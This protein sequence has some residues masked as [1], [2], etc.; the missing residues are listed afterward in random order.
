[1]AADLKDLHAQP[2]TVPISAQLYSRLSKTIVLLYAV[3]LLVT[4]VGVTYALYQ[5]WVVRIEAA[6]TDLSRSASM[7]NF[8]VE[9]ALISAA[10]TLDEAQALFA[11]QLKAGPLTRKLAYQLLRA[12]QTN[13]QNYNKTN[14]FGLLYFV[15]RNGMLFEQSSGALTQAVDLSDRIYFYALRDH[16][17]AQRTVGPLVVSRTTG[18]WVFHMSVPLYG[19][20]GKFAGVLVQQIVENEIAAKLREYADT[21]NFEQLVTHYDGFAPSFVYPPPGAARIPN[22]KFLQAVSHKK[23]D[24]TSAK[25]VVKWDD[26]LAAFFSPVLVGSSISPTYALATYASVPVVNIR[27]DFWTD[28]TYLLVFVALSL[29]SVTAIY[30]YLLNLSRRLAQAQDASL[31]DELTALYNRRALDETLPR[32]LRESMRSQTPVSVL[33]ID[34]DHFRYFNENYGH[35]SGD[36]ALTIVAK[37][38]LSCARRPLDFV[39]R[40]GGEEFV[41]VLP[42]TSRAA[43]RGIAEKILHTV[44][45]VELQSNDGRQPKLT[46]S[47]GHVTATLSK[48]SGQEDLVDEAD[49]AMLVA[50]SRGR[51]QS[52]EYLQ[53]DHACAPGPGTPL[54]V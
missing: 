27:R 36:I 29:V 10:N 15:D 7:G 11:E 41:L 6:K 18:D 2:A 37:T 35:E 13:F 48:D 40:W 23:P 4:A 28:N 9:T 54:A 51:N 50:K 47:V 16:P 12:S 43:A 3:T 30:K 44:R 21:R 31:H 53:A 46:V 42:Q 20:D 19:Q 14:A 5:N 45:A 22:A 39:C 38:L 33:F 24:E 32:L 49:K 52:V 17:E 26:A 34:I 1:M 8:L 25:A